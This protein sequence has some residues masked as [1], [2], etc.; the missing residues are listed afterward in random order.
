MGDEPVTLPFMMLATMRSARRCCSVLTILGPSIRERARVEWVDVSEL[1]TPE[2]NEDASNEDDDVDG[3]DVKALHRAEYVPG[4]ELRDADKTLTV[5]VDG[6][7]DEEEEVGE[8]RGGELTAGT[9]IGDSSPLLPA[10]RVR[11]RNF[12]C[13]LYAS[14]IRELVS[15][16]GGA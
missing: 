11:A 8:L 10:Q 14:S 6:D 7:D 5:D 4:G 13:G 15:K 12:L 2:D 9:R 1:T 3:G 16:R